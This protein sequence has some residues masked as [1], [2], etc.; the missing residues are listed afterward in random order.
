MSQIAKFEETCYSFLV[1]LQNNDSEKIKK[2]KDG[3]NEPPATCYSIL[4][5]VRLFDCD[6]LFIKQSQNKYPKHV[7]QLY[8]HSQCFL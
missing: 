3:Q 4:V 5:K 6:I 2:I 7:T 1:C 8:C